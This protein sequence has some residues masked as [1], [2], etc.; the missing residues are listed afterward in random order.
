M[1]DQPK[2][3][4]KQKVSNIDGDLPFIFVSSY[5][6]LHV[7]IG[8][9]ALAAAK[10]ARK[11]PLVQVDSQVDLQIRDQVEFFGA[12][13]VSALEKTA[14]LL[15]QMCWFASDQFIPSFEFRE[16]DIRI[17]HSV[18]LM[19]R[20]PRTLTWFLFATARRFSASDSSSLLVPLHF[21]ISH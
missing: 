8:R 10:R 14:M 21:Y 15:I 5:M 7:A 1:S 6:I 20:G 4:G 11:R 3:E 2:I 16:L 19:R 17:S 18:L 12:T 13:L 9:E